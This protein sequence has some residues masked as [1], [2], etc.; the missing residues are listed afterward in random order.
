MR[1][2]RQPHAE[3]SATGPAHARPGAGRRLG[4]R[5]ALAA[6]VLLFAAG[7]TSSDAQAGS[8]TPSPGT[9][10]APATTL[11]SPSAGSPTP[12]ST[13]SV[14][15]SPMPTPSATSPTAGSTA[16]PTVTPTPTQAVG[17]QLVRVN[18]DAVAA[19]QKPQGEADCWTV[20][21]VSDREGVWRCGI[22][23][24]SIADPCFATS[25]GSKVACMAQG[26]YMVF[27]V[28]K[29]PVD[30][31]KH[32]EVPAPVMV[33]AQT[34]SGR[35][36]ECYAAS[37]AGPLP[38]KGYT[39]WSGWCSEEGDDSSFTW[40]SDGPGAKASNSRASGMDGVDDA[41]YLRLAYGPQHGGKV[42]HAKVLTAWW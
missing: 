12:S 36:L 3:T 6:A 32:S 42:Q 20:S 1:Q 25:D 31:E 18:A 38:P 8:A 2:T 7:C 23:P 4:G 33:K 26:E 41:G 9:A 5:L 17:T 15:A 27:K 21:N 24:T 28:I 39:S 10:T 30:N 14:T 13:P 19:K 34:E 35:T 22:K 16:S 40:W 37:G 29:K 11:G